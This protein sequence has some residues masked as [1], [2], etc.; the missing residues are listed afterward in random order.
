MFKLSAKG[1]YSVRLMLDLALNYGQGPIALK[2]IAQRQEISEKYLEHLIN[3]L[4]KARLI[5]ANR[6]AYGGYALLKP[7]SEISLKEIIFAVEGPL[8]VVDNGQNLSADC[9]SRGA[10]SELSEK[11][12]E[13]L[14]GLTLEKMIAK[15]IHNSE[16]FSYVI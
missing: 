4:K 13:T 6:G 14:S 15:N 16:E 9:L 10:W 8:C 7:P 5:R 1:R 3:P 11:I 2:D 12:E